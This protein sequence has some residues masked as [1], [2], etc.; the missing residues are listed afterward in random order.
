[1]SIVSPDTKSTL[2][3]APKESTDPNIRLFAEKMKAPFFVAE[4]LW[5]KNIRSAESARSFFLA[6]FQGDCDLS[7][8][9]D[10][11]KAVT[12]LEGVQLNGEKI[13][14]HGDYDVDGISATAIL[15]RALKLCGYNAEY[16]I[17]HRFNDG[18]GI[19]EKNIKKF[20]AQG[21]KWLL[22]VDT[23][24]S[25]LK[26]IT[27]A[28]Q[29]GIKVIVT[30]HHQVPSELPPAEAVVNPNQQGCSYPNKSLCGA[31]LAY[32][33]AVRL[34]M[35]KK[36]SVPD[37]FISLV[38]VASLADIVPVTPENR[39][40]IR[41]GLRLLQVTQHPGLSRLLK[42]VSLHK[43][44]LASTDVLFKISPLLNAPGRLDSPMLSFKL[45]DT[46]NNTESDQLMSVI[47]GLNEKRKL[48]D[49]AI[50]AEAV[51]LIESQYTDTDNSCYVLASEKW[52]EGVIGITAAKLSE[53]YCRPV[54]II[55]ITGAIARGSGRSFNNFNLYKALK[56]CGDTLE[57]WGGHHAAC[58]LSIRP[59][60]I[61]SFRHKINETAESFFKE[62]S[63]KKSFA[64]D[65]CVTLADITDDN[66]V[67]LKRFEPFGPGNESPLFFVKDV[68]LKGN[69]RVVGEE[70][71]KCVVSDGKV[72]YPVIA[73][74]M[75][76]I[77]S[78]LRPGQPLNLAFYP[79]WNYYIN[80][81]T[82]QLRVVA[83]DF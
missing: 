43:K 9:L 1:M 21:I 68:S 28:R 82:I 34:L 75:G 18:Y 73:F 55:S 30:D 2:V 81:R 38:A 25:A 78:Q 5:K 20:K 59:E 54:F 37:Y 53:K 32:L 45:L 31:A 70:H 62:V 79:E 72:H 66:L 13:M 26:E 74:G 10:F 33:L 35:N 6:E 23:G 67:W 42:S 50:F 17:P 40:L 24:V 69:A 64:P 11:E 16:F 36:I 14:V 60:N 77:A 46:D 57:Q 76:H 47:S 52:H 7:L 27:L 39:F 65:I 4:L 56:H 80:R 22:T 12:I 44:E 58:G 48:L 3:Q 8:M 49:K 51:S 19:S 71:L 61:D 29:L 63:T 83:I 41:K 15:Y